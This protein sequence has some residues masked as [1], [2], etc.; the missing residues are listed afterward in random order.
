MAVL[1]IEQQKRMGRVLVSPKCQAIEL[2]GR[3]SKTLF[4][5]SWELSTEAK[6]VSVRL[7]CQAVRRTAARPWRS[8][9]CSNA[10]AWR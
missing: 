3:T 8:M 7:T 2:S 5:S 9:W 1:P 10:R 6:S 4:G